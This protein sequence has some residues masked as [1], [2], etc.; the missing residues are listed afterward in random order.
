[1]RDYEIVG[2]DSVLSG[3]LPKR[4]LLVTFDDGYRSILDV[5]A[6]LL[7]R[8]GIPSVFFVSGAFVRPGSLPLDNLL[9]WLSHRVPL[10]ELES[11][12]TR[13]RATS[14]SFLELVSEIASLPYERRAELRQELAERFGV[15]L[16]KLR[17]EG[18]LF[19]GH[20]ELERL[21]H[22]GVEVGNHTDSHLHCRS[23]VDENVAYTE[24]VRHKLELE[25]WAGARVRSFS[26]PYGNRLDATPL[27]ERVLVGSGHEALFLVE[28]RPNTLRHRGPTWHRVSLRDKPVS[29]LYL[30][31]E[32]LPRLRALRD[33]IRVLTPLKQKS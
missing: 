23:L 15:D 11:V 18:G 14:R 2:L 16:A 25:Q 22:F 5:A 32:L 31:L 9:C 3:R 7:K 24:L 1:M 13:R 26:Y 4:A 17:R 33:L 29:R 10:H 21:S 8:L 6:P 30:E 28:S 19:L 12:I 20:L 27:V